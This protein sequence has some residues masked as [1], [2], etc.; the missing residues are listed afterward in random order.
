MTTALRI[1]LRVGAG[2]A[3][4]LVLGTVLHLLAAPTSVWIVA[5]IA[6][7]VGFWPSIRWDS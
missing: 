1:L 5:T 2:I 4:G 3:A 7:C 6:C